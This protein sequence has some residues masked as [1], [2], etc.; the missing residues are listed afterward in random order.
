MTHDYKAALEWFNRANWDERVP[1]IHATRH[2]LLIADKLMQE[3]SRE[4][5]DAGVAT[6]LREHETGLAN[7]AEWKATRDQMLKEISDGK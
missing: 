5:I 4:M 1:E 2:A 3:P 6:W 7:A